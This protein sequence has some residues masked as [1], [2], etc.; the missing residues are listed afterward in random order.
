MKNN[1]INLNKKFCLVTGSN[2]HI[3]KVICE[4]LLKLVETVIH[5]D[6]MKNKIKSKNLIDQ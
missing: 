3:G 1:F 5:T 2:G 4:K 6:I